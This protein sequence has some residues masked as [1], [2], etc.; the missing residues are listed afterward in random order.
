M[1]SHNSTD[2]QKK[3]NRTSVSRELQERAD[4]IT[5]ELQ[6]ALVPLQEEID[7]RKRSGRYS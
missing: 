3:N 6:D 2:N 4:I 7:I 5:R 1:E